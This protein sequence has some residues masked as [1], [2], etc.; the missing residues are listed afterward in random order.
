LNSDEDRTWFVSLLDEQLENV[1]KV[2][3]K[4]ICKTAI[5]TELFEGMSMYRQVKLS[6]EEIL[7]M[8]MKAL[9]EHNRTAT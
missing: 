4:S 3:D 7:G 9:D 8:C 5:F 2:E 1:F 6:R